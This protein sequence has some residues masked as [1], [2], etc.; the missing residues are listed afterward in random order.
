MVRGRAIVIVPVIAFNLWHRRLLPL[1]DD[2]IR[3]LDPFREQSF[4]I[5]FD[6]L[7][8]LIVSPF[9]SL[10]AS[11]LRLIGGCTK[12][13][14]IEYS[15]INRD[16]SWQRR[17]RGHQACMLEPLPVQSHK[18]TLQLP[19]IYS[20]ATSRT[21]GSTF[22]ATASCCRSPTSLTLSGRIVC[23]CWSGNVASLYSP[24]EL[25]F[26]L[27]LF[28]R[29]W[30]STRHRGLICNFRS[31]GDDGSA[32][33]E[34]RMQSGFLN[35]HLPCS[36]KTPNKSRANSTTPYAC[37]RVETPNSSFNSG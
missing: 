10:G 2:M 25:K 20:T 14:R 27:A 18:T 12:R 16:G 28:I 4:F 31:R 26:G 9:W 36:L 29:D 23:G 21:S 15:H 19:R 32:L 17:C 35:L 13:I 5:I 24:L 6:L 3:L 11:Q 30:F 1:F 37:L 22:H 34:F 7:F 8:R 33:W